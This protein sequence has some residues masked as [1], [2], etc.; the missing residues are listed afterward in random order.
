M[1]AQR[2]FLGAVDSAA[3]ERAPSSLRARVSLLQPGARRSGSGGLRVLWAASAVGVGAAA[4]VAVV[5]VMGGQTVAPTVAQAAVL[6]L[7]APQAH[8][9]QRAANHGAL[10]AVRAAGLT[11]PYWEDHFGYRATGVRYDRL[12]GRRITTVYYLRGPSRVAYEI[13]SGTPLQLGGQT[14][15]AERQGVRLRTM[16][17]RSGLVVTWL[18]HGHTC[19]LVGAATGMPTLLRLAAWHQGGRVP[20]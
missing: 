4:V 9:R 17:T 11:Y 12:G 1:A 8:V 18:R 15:S 7:R 2:R 14:R 16:N 5:L 6:N 10:P 3:R 13:V 19:I 20:Y